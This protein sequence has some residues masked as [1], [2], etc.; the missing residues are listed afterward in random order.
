MYGADAELKRN[1]F[2]LKD[3][4]MKDI[5]AEARTYERSS[6]NARRFMGGESELVRYSDGAGNREERKK[7]PKLD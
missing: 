3:I 2:K 6:L 5:I 1:F 4:T 7:G